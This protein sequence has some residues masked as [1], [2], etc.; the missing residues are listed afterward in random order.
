[1]HLQSSSIV[2]LSPEEDLSDRAG[3]GGSAK[4]P[5]RPAYPPNTHPKTSP[6]IDSGTEHRHFFSS[7]ANV[8]LAGAAAA[9]GMAA[10]LKC[11]WLLAQTRASPRRLLSPALVMC[12]IMRVDA[13]IFCSR[14]GGLP[15]K[16]AQYC[17]PC[18][19]RRKYTKHNTPHHNTTQHNTTQHT[20]PHHTTPQH[21]T[22]HH[23]TTHHNTTHHTTPH[24]NTTRH[25]T[26]QHNTTQHNTTQHNTT[27][28]NTTQ[29]NT[30]QHN[31]TQ[32]NTTQHNTTQ[33]NTTQH[34]TPQHTTPQHNTPQHNTTQ[35]SPN[36]SF[37]SRQALRRNSAQNNTA[38]H[39]APGCFGAGCVGCCHTCVPVTVPNTSPA[40]SSL[41]FNGSH[42]AG[43]AAQPLVSGPAQG[44]YSP[45]PEAAMPH[46]RNAAA[47]GLGPTGAPVFGPGPAP[48]AAQTAPTA[49]TP[50]PAAGAQA[51]PGAPPPAAQMAG[52]PPE[53][54]A[55][56]QM[57]GMDRAQ[58]LLNSILQN[59][60]GLSAS[61]RP[62]EGQ[63]KGLCP[64]LLPTCLDLGHWDNC[65]AP[66][67]PTQP[68]QSS[69]EPT[70][71]G[72]RSRCRVDLGR[73]SSLEHPLTRGKALEN[74]STRPTL[75]NGWQWWGNRA[76]NN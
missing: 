17:S 47:L 61:P 35:H 73:S 27:Q 12:V 34:N 58:Q 67:P 66:I 48:G 29:H 63:T 72:C 39:R 25:D 10:R 42:P 56:G 36:R 57:F 68:K 69:H 76:R 18:E 9:K 32:H 24:H 16:E 43:S 74:G 4:I 3:G 53:L 30:T 70:H 19:A 21:T 13:M 64:S 52:M 40:T 45:V 37:V 59:V 50:G 15:P 51:I 11:L 44:R 75:P 31:T 23:N 38:R 26:T 8:P 60:S 62:S 1:M 55:F 20:T 6:N 7:I 46:S 5:G 71:G 28:H 33:H 65:G 54:L 41:P 49:A 22:P 2:R 14:H